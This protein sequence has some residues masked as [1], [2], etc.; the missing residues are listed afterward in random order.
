M[1]RLSATGELLN[2][3]DIP[4]AAAPNLA[5]GPGGQTLYITAVDDT[6]HAPWPGKVYRLVL[7]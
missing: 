2:T 7:S 5:L 1:L 3:V 4:A 6:D